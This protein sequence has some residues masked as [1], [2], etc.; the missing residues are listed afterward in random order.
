MLDPDRLASVAPGARLVAVAHLPETRLVFRIDRPDLGGGLPSVEQAAGH[1]VWGAVFDVP[2]GEL[3]A[4]D[5]VEGSEGRR[6]VDGF[7]AVDR[8]GTPYEVWTHVAAE[9]GTE[10]VPSS[11]YLRHVLAGARALGLPTGW[12][13]GLEELGGDPLL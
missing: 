6:R 1:T 12:I 5:A 10:T 2:D 3:A 11:A 7:R 9:R 13:I 8:D 4:L